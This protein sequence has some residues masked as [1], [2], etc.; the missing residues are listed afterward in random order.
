MKKTIIFKNVISLSTIKPTLIDWMD[1]NLNNI[2]KL[3]SDKTERERVMLIYNMQY[4]PKMLK[5][6][7]EKR[8][9]KKYQIIM[10]F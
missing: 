9:L 10:H 1:L 4:F 7:E 3:N 5:Q 2:L 6:E 8:K